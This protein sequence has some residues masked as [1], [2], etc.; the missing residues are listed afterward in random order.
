MKCTLLSLNATQYKQQQ[1][2]WITEDDYTVKHNEAILSRN[3]V[4]PSIM[5]KHNYKLFE[6]DL[7]E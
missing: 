5:C 4:K 6:M 7:E 3:V 1:Q 2:W